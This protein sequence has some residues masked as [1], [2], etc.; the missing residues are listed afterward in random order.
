MANYTTVIT[1]AGIAKLQAIANA[2]GT[3]QWR[4]VK[5]GSGEIGVGDPKALTDIITLVQSFGA[6]VTRTDQAGLPFVFF[7]TNNAGLLAGY[8][9]MEVGIFGREIDD[10]TDTLI[11]Y[12]Y[13]PTEEDAD[14][15]PA[16]A[17][18]AATQTFRVQLAAAQGL[19]AT[20][21]IDLTTVFL[22]LD[23]W[24]DHLAG[25]GGV[26]QHIVATNAEPG[27]MSAADKTALDGHIGA[28]GAAH[29]NATQQASG[30]ES[31][32]DKTK[33]DGIAAGAEVNQNTF[34]IIKAAEV[35]VQAD[36]K[37]DTVEFAGSEYIDIQGDAG[38]DKITF[39][40]RGLAPAT[41]VGT[42]GNQH[43]AAT[44]AV[45]GFESA[46]DKTKLDGIEA[47][48]QVNSPD[49]RTIQIGGGV[50]NAPNVG[51]RLYIANTDLI[52]L[53]ADDLNKR[54]NIGLGLPY[55]LIRSNANYND[56]LA[57]LVADADTISGGMYPSPRGGLHYCAQNINHPQR[58]TFEMYIRNA[59]AQAVNRTVRVSYCDNWLCYQIDA[60]AVTVLLNEGTGTYVD[61]DVT[62]SIPAGAHTIRWYLCSNAAQTDLRLGD[63][64]DGTVY[65][66][67]GG[68][69][70]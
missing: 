57:N 16:E 49:I 15:I 12:L 63:W 42:G 69:Y 9:R 3:L 53:S 23:R 46:A 34:A 6:P 37:Q 27:L 40:A 50:I 30:F 26:D 56:D 31:A 8:N 35:N 28:G 47:G 60:G 44:Q 17:A 61:Q 52:V 13:A 24:A 21:D 36:A 29:A 1:D 5:C 54:I 45:A 55:Y 22:A 62:I 32:A 20:A 59:S 67:P 2:A 68:V 64:L 25:A 38:N 48:A 66:E 65:W 14:F 33:L 10:V 51:S 4:A 7:T 41:H 11:L 70:Y 39:T 18:G 58:V 19:T 43:P